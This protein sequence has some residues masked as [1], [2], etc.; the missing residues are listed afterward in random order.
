MNISIPLLLL[1]FS[2]FIALGMPEGL[3][4]VAWPGIQLSFSLR[5]DAIGILLASSICGY[6]LSSFFSG[7]MVQRLGFGVLLALSS[8]LT[9]MALL[10]IALA[11]QWWMLLAG[12]FVVGLG[13][14]AVDA[15]LNTYVAQNHSP[16]LMQ[17][18]HAFFGVGVTAGPLI[19]TV[20]LSLS[21]QWQP[22]FLVVALVQLMLALAFL[23]Y[24]K[25]WIQVKL[26]AREE[27]DRAHEPVIS[28]WSSLGQRGT[29]LSMLMFFTYNGIEM[30]LGLWV[31]SIL[32]E[33]NN[34]SHHLAGLVTGSYWAMFTL[35]RF[36]AGLLAHRFKPTS[37]VISAYLL[38]MFGLLLFS[39]N[40]SIS[41]SVLGIAIA[42][43]AIAPIFPSLVSDTVR[44]VGDRHSHNVFGIQM[45]AAG[46]GAAAIQW[47]A[48][49]IAELFSLAYIPWFL[50][51]LTG[52]ALISLLLSLYQPDNDQRP[53]QSP[54]R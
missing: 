2:A 43:F 11:T 36:L 5:E 1:I 54:D 18:L 33:I 15:G 16:R 21:G 20:A 42:G 17:W 39:L 31:Y 41:I 22:G 28:L 45:A 8:L 30:G 32:T 3:L 47:L 19:M 35:G 4:G 50:L 26:P 27:T 29:I 25:S 23:R 53:G 38:A 24:R 51:A 7:A 10:A 37:L 40:L 12:A 6:I 49:G 9:A 13:G 46:A 14:G 34:V 44:R 48:G 52:L